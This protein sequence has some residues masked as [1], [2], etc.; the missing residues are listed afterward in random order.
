MLISTQFC[1]IFLAMVQTRR[2]ESFFLFGPRGAGKSTWFVPT[3]ARPA[4]AYPPYATRTATR[5]IVL[6]RYPFGFQSMACGCIIPSL[7]VARAH[8]S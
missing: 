1:G 4:S 7:S 2:I 8:I 6:L 3:R 5:C